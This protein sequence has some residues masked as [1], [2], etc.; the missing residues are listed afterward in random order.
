MEMKTITLELVDTREKQDKRG[1]LIARAEEWVGG[2]A[3]SVYRRRARE[4]H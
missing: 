2:V 3:R 1:R 4:R